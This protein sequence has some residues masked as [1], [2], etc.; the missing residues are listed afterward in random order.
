LKSGQNRFIVIVIW[1]LLYSMLLILRN[2]C[3]TKNNWRI[4]IISSI[5]K[6]YQSMSA[7]YLPH[8]YNMSYGEK[9]KNNVGSPCHRGIAVSRT[10]RWRC[11]STVARLQ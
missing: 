9:N 4:L 6:T 1:G 10:R 11:Y 3:L 5:H 2:M 8:L 7:I